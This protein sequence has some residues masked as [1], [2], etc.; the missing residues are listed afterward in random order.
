M[1]LCQIFVLSIS[2][3]FIDKVTSQEIHSTVHTTENGTCWTHTACETSPEQ[4][5]KQQSG[6]VSSNSSASHSKQKCY[7]WMFHNE[8][9]GA[10]ECSDIPYRAVLCDPTIPRTSILDCYCMTY[11]AKRNEVELGRCLYGCGHKKDIVYYTLP[12]NVSDLNDYTC[13]KTNRDSTFCGGC[14]PG[15]SPLVYS[16]DLSCMNCTGMTYNWIKYIAVAYIPLTFFYFFIVIFRFSGTSPLLRS[17]I[18]MCQG[19]ASPVCVRAVLTVS[20]RETYTNVFV[21]ILGTVYGIWNL[22]FFRLVIPPI[23]LNIPSLQALALDYAIAFYPFLLIF[24]TYILIR[25][26]SHDVR[27]IVWLWKPFHKLFHSIKQD[28]DMEGSLIQAFA[29]LFMISYLKILN[30][31]VD[32]LVYTDKYM[33]PLSKQSYRV[34]HALY[35]DASVEYFRGYHLYYG[36]TA[37]LIGIFVVILPLVF[38]VVY[39][40]RWFQKCLNKLEI[41]RQVIDMFVNCYQGHYKDGTNGTTDLRFFSISFFVLQITIYILYTL[42]ESIYCYSL[43]A[44]IIVLLMFTILMV[45]PY[46]EQFKAY[47]KIDAYMLVTI[48]G[49]FIMATAG[50]QADVKAVEYSKLSYTLMGVMAILH[51]LYVVG[52]LIWWVFVKKN[53]K[54]KL[55]CFQAREPE[56]S[57]EESY[58]ATDL[59]DRIEHPTIYES[60]CA[61]LLSVGQENECGHCPKYGS[62]QTPENLP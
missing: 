8:M 61:P 16:Y 34:K 5:E 17:Y 48:A 15:Y 30:V 26:Y 41:K 4:G 49:V 13:S 37:I 23:C 43:G 21:K 42:S 62:A 10:C 29:T 35:Y 2:L 1:V 52:L 51:I 25:L 6:R 45:Q 28:W 44:L 31:T 39:P 11:N 9:S 59:P 3:L 33:L 56:H 55:P 19:I 50:S 27:F 22:D 60:P 32:L 38:L 54:R 14:K 58:C 46:K 57:L 53:L 47:S 12:Q 36:I 24:L 7:P 40:M 20:G 18:N